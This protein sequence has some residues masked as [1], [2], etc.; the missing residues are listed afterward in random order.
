[1]T[2]TFTVDGQYQYTLS[3]PSS[4]DEI[5]LESSGF[6]LFKRGPTVYTSFPPDPPFSFLQLELQT[7]T[8]LLNTA[9]VT[10]G[11]FPEAGVSDAGTSGA[12]Y[13]FVGG[14]VSSVQSVPEPASL[15][16]LALSGLMLLRRRP[17]RR[18]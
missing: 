17:A 13:Y 2:V 7:S 10:L 11:S 15:G 5:D 16:L 9:V 8:D 6:D 18:W 1:M 12:G 4:S 14:T 3:T